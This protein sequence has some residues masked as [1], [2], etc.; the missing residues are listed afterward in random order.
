MIS[1]CKRAPRCPWLLSLAFTCVRGST[2][3][4]PPTVRMFSFVENFLVISATAALFFNRSR[5]WTYEALMLSPLSPLKYQFVTLT[6][7]MITLLD[8][9][10][11]IFLGKSSLHDYW[12]RWICFRHTN[13]S[14]VFCKTTRCSVI[15]RL[16]TDSNAWGTNGSRNINERGLIQ[17]NSGCQG[18]M[19]MEVLNL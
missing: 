17:G 19:V 5:W 15:A 12:S 10:K 16:T 11:T 13:P 14:S 8:V 6:Y 3:K 2:A 4:D 18:S 1:C 7:N 9:W